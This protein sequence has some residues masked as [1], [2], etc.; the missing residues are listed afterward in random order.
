MAKNKSSSSV[1]HHSRPPHHHLWWF[2]LSALPFSTRGL[3]PSLKLTALSLSHLD[4]AK[5]MSWP[6]GLVVDCGLWR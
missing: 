6:W 4:W 5:A 1:C 3:S 2:Y